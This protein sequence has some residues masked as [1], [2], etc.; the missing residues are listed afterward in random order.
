[1]LTLICYFG[2]T[3]LKEGQGLN[4]LNLTDYAIDPCLKLS[5]SKTAFPCRIDFAKCVPAQKQCFPI[6][7]S[8]IFQS[9]IS[10]GSKCCTHDHF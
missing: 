2:I 4:Q 3:L 5:Y 7:F 10:V 6:Y 1:M 9:V 8:Y